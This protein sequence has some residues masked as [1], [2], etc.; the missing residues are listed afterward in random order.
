MRIGI[1]YDI[2]PLKKGIQLILGGETIEYHKGL[3]GHSDADVLIHALIDA[4]LGASGLGDIGMYFPDSQIEWKGI[5]SMILLEKTLQ[6]VQEEKMRVHNVDFAVIAE[7][8]KLFPYF[9]KIRH[10]LSKVLKVGQN[11]VNLK[12][13]TNEKLGPIGKGEAIAVFCVA[14][15]E[16]DVL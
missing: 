16:E 3:I 2:H 10:N 9:P 13:T 7:E 6:I 14:L 1:G 15:L 11:R 4:L 8:P 5:S 12:A